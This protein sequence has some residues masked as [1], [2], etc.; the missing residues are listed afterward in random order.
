LLRTSQ[1]KR[2]FINNIYNYD[3]LTNIRYADK[4]FYTQM[5]MREKDD[6]SDYVSQ[7]LYYGEE[8]IQ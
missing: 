2:K 4:M 8:T 6:T 1:R 3:I 7:V 5:T